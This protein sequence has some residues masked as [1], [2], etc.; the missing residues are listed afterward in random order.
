M[1]VN[2]QTLQDAE[3]ERQRLLAQISADHG[4]DW[5]RAYEPGSFGCHELLD[6]TSLA[7]DVLE[8]FVSSHPSCVQN[9]EWYELAEQA[10]AALRELYQRIGAQHLNGNGVSGE[11][12]N[13]ANGTR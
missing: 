13:P 1:S 3:Q 11:N 12:G 8:R 5:C 4:P 6:R 9:P 10:L 2:T 7:V